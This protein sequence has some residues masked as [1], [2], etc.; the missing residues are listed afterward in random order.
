[1]LGK[2]TGCN[3]PMKGERL[4]KVSKLL[5]VEAVVNVTIQEKIAELEGKTLPELQVNVLSVLF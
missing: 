4:Q 2:K 5:K 3:L 1:L